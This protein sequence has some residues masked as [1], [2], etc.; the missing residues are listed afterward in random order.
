MNEWSI[1]IHKDLNEVSLIQNFL[2]VSLTAN[3]LPRSI[4]L[5]SIYFYP[6]N[7]GLISNYVFQ[8]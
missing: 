8:L 2:T 6:K 3:S 1:L 4:N 7:K 5:N